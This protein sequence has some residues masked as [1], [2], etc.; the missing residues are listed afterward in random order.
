MKI[1]CNLTT[2]F[3][4]SLRVPLQT[5]I[6][7][8]TPNELS[9]CITLKCKEPGRS[10]PTLSVLCLSASVRLSPQTQVTPQ[11]GWRLQPSVE[12]CRT[13]AQ[14]TPESRGTTAHTATARSTGNSGGNH[15]AP[16]FRAPGLAQN[17]RTRRA[18]ATKE[19]FGARDTRSPPRASRMGTPDTARV[20]THPPTR[21]RPAPHGQCPRPPPPLRATGP[22]MR[23]AL[24]L[25]PP[26]RCER[27]RSR[28]SVLA[29]SWARPLSL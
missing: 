16:R 5:R 24:A 18:G 28:V 13:P 14:H 8:T 1:C 12:P 21:T 20:S 22:P 23:C 6:H 7:P 27:A 10:A 3:A 9:L 26:R 25:A 4:S 17:P 29:A 11:V 19:S 2:C 15:T